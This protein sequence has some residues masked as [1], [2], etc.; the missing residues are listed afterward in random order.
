MSHDIEMLDTPSAARA[1]GLSPS[2]LNKWRTA[3]SGPAF[4]RMGA[5]IRYRRADLAAFIECRVVAST[6]EAKGRRS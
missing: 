3:G 1:L 6:A 2:T 4:V 5:A